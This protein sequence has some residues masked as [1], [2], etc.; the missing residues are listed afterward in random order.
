VLA[1]HLPD[2]RGRSGV[3]ADRQARLLGAEEPCQEDGGDAERAD[4][5][6]PGVDGPDDTCDLGVNLAVGSAEG[7]VSEVLG[8]TEASR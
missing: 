6:P 3:G 4:R 2:R 7:E 1:P 5:F 8:G